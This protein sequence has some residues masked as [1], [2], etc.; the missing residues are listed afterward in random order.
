MRLLRTQS[1]R[2]ESAFI[3]KKAQNLPDWPLRLLF[4][5]LDLAKRK[6]ADRMCQLPADNIGLSQHSHLRV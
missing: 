6:E 5:W 2:S 1:D 3:K 4:P